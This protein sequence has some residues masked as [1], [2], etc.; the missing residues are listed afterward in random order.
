MCVSLALRADV[1]SKT[2]SPNGEDSGYNRVLE[3]KHSKIIV[4][5]C[6]D[7]CDFGLDSH[8]WG[9]TFELVLASHSFE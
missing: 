4:F 1:W 9:E 6:S 2:S 3:I 7:E 8:C 5:G